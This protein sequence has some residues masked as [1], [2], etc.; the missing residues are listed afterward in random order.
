ML[1]NSFGSLSGADGVGI[2][3]GSCGCSPIIPPFAA[4]NG[5]PWNRQVAKP[6]ASLCPDDAR[7]PA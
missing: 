3:C 4:A 5:M 7:L 6:V 2:S 1:L